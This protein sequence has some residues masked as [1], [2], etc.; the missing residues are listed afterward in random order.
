ML[1][2][3]TALVLIAC[4]VATALPQCGRKA[5]RRPREEVQT[6]QRPGAGTAG[7][8]GNRNAPGSKRPLSRAALETIHWLKTRGI[9]NQ[10]AGR[11]AA[12]E[13]K[14]FTDEEALKMRT[15]NLME[16]SAIEDSELKH[17]AVLTVLQSLLM[18]STRLTDEGLSHLV[19]LKGLEG[20]MVT[21]PKITDRGLIHIGGLTALKELYLPW[22]ENIKG[23]GLVHLSRLSRLK[24]LDLRGTKIHDGA[25]A[26]LRPLVEL[27][28]LVLSFTGITDAGLAHLGKLKRLADLNL[29]STRIT[30]KG[31]KHLH[32]IKSLRRLVLTGTNVDEKAIR[33]LKK[34]LPRCIIRKRAKVY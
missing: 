21:G 33:K 32:P 3:T 10:G 1:H 8:S 16:G 27:E 6:G 17:L 9:R 30:T 29:V 23:P 19:A 22:N 13:G 34:S 28:K 11:F 25:L 2:R 15:L 4:F 20:L 18:R 12:G 26:H 24:L 31:L 14:D 5:K 7:T